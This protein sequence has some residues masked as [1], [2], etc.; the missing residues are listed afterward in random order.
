TRTDPEGRFTIDGA[1]QG[2]RLGLFVFAGLEKYVPEN[3]LLG[4]SADAADVDAGTIPLVP[5]NP[6]LRPDPPGTLG[7]SVEQVD[8]GGLAVARVEAGGP[9]ARAGIQL[10]EPLL[11]I[12]G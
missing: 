5:G 10:G 12:D 1:P 11:A 8:T 4:A 6:H 9:A 2:R 7:L 3:W